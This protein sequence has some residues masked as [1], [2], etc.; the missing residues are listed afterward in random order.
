MATAAPR[1]RV[2]ADQRRASILRAAGPQFARDGYAGARLEDIAAGARVTK[3]IV[4]RHFASKKAL[5]LA[6]LAKHQDDL[7]TF[8]QGMGDPAREDPA[9][10]VRAVLERWLDYVRENRHAWVM[11]FRDTT[12]DA[13]IRAFR[14][15]VSVRA[16]E[17]MAA[18]VAAKSAGALPPAEVDATAELLR[19]GLAGLALWWIDHPDTPK[20]VVVEVASRLST[21]ALGGGLSLRAQ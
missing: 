13:E 19:S 5:Y 3:P 1:R 20:P 8:F 17:V 14:R 9:E 15:R 2:P 10:L 11:L 18:L 12:G 6:L 4:Y 21:A 16:H 7:P